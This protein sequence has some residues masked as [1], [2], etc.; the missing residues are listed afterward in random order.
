[1]CTAPGS[2]A[3]FTS[4]PA[5]GVPAAP[6]LVYVWDSLCDLAAGSWLIDYTVTVTSSSGLVQCRGAFTVAN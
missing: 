1:M 3:P 2:P 4:N 5:T 6:G